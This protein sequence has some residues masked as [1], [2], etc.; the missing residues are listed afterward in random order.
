MTPLNSF[1]SLLDIILYQRSEGK[2]EI[3]NSFL[4]DFG[5]DY[6]IPAL[7]AYLVYYIFIKETNRDKSKILQQKKEEQ[8]DKLFFFATITKSGISLSERQKN[9]LK[10]HIRAMKSDHIT[11]NF[12]KIVPLVD[13]KRISEKLNLEEYLLAYTDVYND[14][15]DESIKE[16]QNIISSFDFLYN[17]FTMI[18]TELINVQKHDYERKLEFKECYKKCNYLLGKVLLYFERIGGEEYR[19]ISEAYKHFVDNHPADNYDIQYYHDFFF[20][21]LHDF[22]VDYLNNVRA[23]N[24]DFHDFEVYLK[25]GILVLK[26]I[27]AENEQTRM[28]LTKDFKEIART[29]ISLKKI[30]KRMIDDIYGR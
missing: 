27:K 15:R 7:G 16:F 20:I 29:I 14:K 10:N 21:P 4:Y 1:Q 6:I 12:L 11:F 25:E 28:L 9:F 5:K 18:Q 3:G 19:R 17:A 30:S 8:N 2:G 13:L 24:Q 23:F 22:I 26:H